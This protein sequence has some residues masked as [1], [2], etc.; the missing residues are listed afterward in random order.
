MNVIG[1][2]G[3]EKALRFLFFTVYQ[4][5]LHICVVPQIRAFLLTLAGAKIGEGTVLLDIRFSNLHHHGFTRLRMGKRVFVGDGALL[6]TRGGILLGDDVT[7]SSRVILITH[8]NVGFPGHPLQKHYPPKEGKITIGEGAYLG[9]AAIVLP[10]ITIGKMAVVGA[11]AV[12]TK[13]VA[14]KTVEVGVPARSIKRIK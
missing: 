14:A 2:I 10:G 8:T 9:T 3:W 11:G 4:F 13:D 6:D 1:I 5:L 7:I 12:V